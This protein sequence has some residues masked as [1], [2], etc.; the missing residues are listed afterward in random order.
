VIATIAPVQ[1]TALVLAALGATAVAL[2]MNPLRQIVLS[3][4]YGL[5]LAILFVTL[6]APD[7]ALSML[8][9]STV[10]APLIVLAAITRSRQRTSRKA[11]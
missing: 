11:E 6:Q 5:V 3:S 1:A 7:V 10:A 9:V 2:C 4:V 8:V